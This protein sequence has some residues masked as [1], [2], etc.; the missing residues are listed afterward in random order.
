ML[1]VLPHH[2]TTKT[3]RLLQ[4]EVEGMADI[5]VRGSDVNSDGRMRMVAFSVQM[6]MPASA[7]V[8][9]W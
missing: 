7:S 4:S 5:G 1:Q 2:A 9:A 6:D 8:M 3:T